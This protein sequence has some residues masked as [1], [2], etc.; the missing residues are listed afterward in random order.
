MRGDGDPPGADTRFLCLS[1]QDAVSP[2]R[3]QPGESG[4]YL[5]S[6]LLTTAPSLGAVPPGLCMA[7]GWGPREQI[8]A[9]CSLAPA[10][11]AALM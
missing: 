6:P 2:Y 3:T 10:L 4:S 5:V 11:H 7:M 8:L 1:A 9:V